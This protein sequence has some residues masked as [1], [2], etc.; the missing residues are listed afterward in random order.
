MKHPAPGSTL[1]PPR[2]AALPVA[3]A[4]RT[5][6]AADRLA[7]IFQAAD[8]D[9][10]MTLVVRAA[11]EIAEANTGFVVLADPVLQHLEPETARDERGRAPRSSVVHQVVAGSTIATRLAHGVTV[12]SATGVDEGWVV[13]PLVADSRLQGA[14]AVAIP[15]ANGGQGRIVEALRDLCRQVAPL[16]ARLRELENLRAM[17]DGLAALVHQGS[18]YEARLRDA[19]N[20]LRQLRLHDAL[21][22][23]LVAGVNHALRTP[24][25]AIRGYAR[26]LQEAETETEGPRK[27][28]LDVVARNT[29]RLVEVA[30]NLWLP[31][32]HSVPFAPVDLRAL[33]TSALAAARPCAAAREMTLVERLP[34]QPVSLLGDAAALEQMLDLLIKAVIAQA[35]LGQ[36]LRAELRDDGAR[37]VVCVEIDETARTG[38]VD[39][40]GG[41]A[42]WLDAVREGANRHGGWMTV[43][44]GTKA[45]LKLSIVLPRVGIDK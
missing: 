11:N 37:V 36:T 9:E 7:P 32:R 19:E 26:L 15:A 12:R 1:P 44:R 43:E 31:A 25:V 39:D 18:L 35:P 28:Q 4:V 10:L 24:L 38:A 13:L 42:M 41:V 3:N 20:E 22:T 14:V 23:E 21:R 5:R 34:E 40:D 27:R 17:N 30:R 29:E 45:S 33:F 16:V 6:T 8:M 2:R